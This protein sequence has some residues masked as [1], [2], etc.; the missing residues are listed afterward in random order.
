[1]HD[2][3]ITKT[4][5]YL[6]SLRFNFGVDKKPIKISEDIFILPFDNKRDNINYLKNNWNINSTYVENIE[7]YGTFVLHSLGKKRILKNVWESH[8]K[9]SNLSLAVRLISYK[10]CDNYITLHYDDSLKQVLYYPTSSSGHEV[11]TDRNDFSYLGKKDV[12]R[13]RNLYK[14]I[15]DNTFPD[16]IDPD[17]YSRLNNALR[18]YNIAYSTDWHLMKV[19]LLFVSLESLFSD[20]DDHS[21]ISYKVRLRSSYL[22]FPNKKDK[23]KRQEIF[24]HL[25]HGYDIRSKFLHG[26]NVEKEILKKQK[27]HKIGE[28]MY[29]TDYLPI[30]NKIVSDILSKVLEDNESLK[31]FSKNKN[32]SDE[33]KLFFGDLVL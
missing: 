4:L 11:Y 22:L 16:T 20:K 15:E 30:L 1:M 7:S 9:F 2:E 29:L 13:L 32:E 19:I 27:K 28:F 14:K 12:K 10:K 8:D 3:E 21:D 5:G 33:D 26:D 25:K 31:F 17:K 6:K 24:E 18:F 23:E